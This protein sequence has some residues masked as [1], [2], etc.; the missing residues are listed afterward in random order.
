MAVIV[1]T[2]PLLVAA[3]RADEAHELAVT[4]LDLGGRDV[5]APD[6]VIAECDHVLRQRAGHDAA[7]KLLATL[8]AGHWT[9]AALSLSLFARAVEIDLRYADLGLGVADASVMA[10]AESTSSAILAFDFRDFRAAPPL[11]GERGDCSLDEA[12]YAK[13]V[14]AR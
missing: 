11:R 13:M 4:L 3:R 14:R 7:R 12:E 5:L 10:L 8:R 6:P 1:D 2:G 9:R